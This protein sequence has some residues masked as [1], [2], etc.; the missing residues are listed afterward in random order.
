[1]TPRRVIVTLEIETSAPLAALRNKDRVFFEAYD[2]DDCPVE[3]SIK[4]VQANV[5]RA[6]KSTK[7]PKRR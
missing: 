3:L 1:M 5:I 2:C 7:T 4:Q 6:E